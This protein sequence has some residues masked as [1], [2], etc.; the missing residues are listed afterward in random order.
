MFEQ[1]IMSAAEWECCQP[2]P[3][4]NPERNPI[5]EKARN[6]KEQK[7]HINDRVAINFEFMRYQ[8]FCGSD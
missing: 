7:K 6:F 4:K 3:M 5:W 8:H 2:W 1:E